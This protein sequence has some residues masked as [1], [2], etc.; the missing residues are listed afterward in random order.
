MT[1]DAVDRIVEQWASERAELDTTAMEVFGRVIRLARL[2]GDEVG[3]VYDQ[4]G[5][6]RPEFDVLATLRRSGP[7]YQLSPGSLAA[8][9]MM[10]SGGT[11]ARLDRLEQRG[12]IRRSADPDDRR[13]VLVALTEP[14]ASWSMR[15]SPPAWPGSRSCWPT[16]RPVSSASSPGCSVR[17]SD[18]WRTD[19]GAARPEVAFAGASAT[20][21]GRRSRADLGRLRVPGRFR[22]SR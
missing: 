20:W 17:C 3:R 9:M 11:T 6:G 22:H 21:P 1:A 2:A 5:I 4:H 19:V 14:A 16:C 15:R 10:S 7:P 8:A 13:G 12:L 18:P